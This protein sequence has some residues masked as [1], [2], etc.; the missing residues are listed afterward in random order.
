MLMKKL[1]LDFLEQRF[2]LLSDDKDSANRLQRHTQ[3]FRS[4]NAE[5]SLFAEVQPVL[6]FLKA[7]L[8]QDFIGTKKNPHLFHHLCGQ[9]GI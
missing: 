9:T 1:F 6:A 5:S 4:E 3:T 8:R 2:V 7:K